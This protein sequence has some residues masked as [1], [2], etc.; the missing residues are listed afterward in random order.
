MVM[1]P[2]PHPARVAIVTAFLCL[3]TLLPVAGQAPGAGGLRPD[4][5]SGPIQDRERTAPAG[6][7]PNLESGVFQSRVETMWVQSPTFRRQ[8]Q[9]LAAERPLVVTLL[10]HPSQR[11][12]SARAST[13]FFRRN[14]RV[15]SARVAILSSTD[16]V[17][18][19]A[20]EIE[21]IIEQLDDIAPRGYSSTSS[22][23][24]AGA[25]YES[26]RAVEVGRRVAHEVEENSGRVVMRIRQGEQLRGVL[27]PASASVSAD[28][29]FIAFTSAAKLAT[30]DEDDDVDLY[31]LDLQ[32][33]R[34]T[35]ESLSSGW[36]SHYRPIVF[37]RISGNGRFIVFQAVPADEPSPHWQVVVLDRPEGTAHMVSVDS[38][39]RP[40]NGHCTQAAISAD[41]SSVV[42]ESNATNLVESGDANRNLFDIYLVRLSGGGVTRVSVASDGSRP[43]VGHSITP[44]LSGDGRYVAF[45]S[46]ADLECSRASTCRAPSDGKGVAQIYVR[47]TVSNTTSRVSRS[48]NGKAPNGPSSWPAI[49]GDGRHVVFVSEAS[50]LIR[51]DRNGEADIRQNSV[52]LH[53]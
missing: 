53:R 6:P 33:G 40:A 38:N 41:G 25:A 37:P 18:L 26:G 14:G 21:Q 1:K 28:G 9:R 22:M 8:C 48:S 20:H 16:A 29:R 49:S 11:P 46:E 35:L 51:G 5:I 42:F 34:T 2:C 32:T 31:V 24:G 44:A 52:V 4:V 30:G 47:D 12:A 3:F 7:P 45:R 19:I 27:N 15:T 43:A 10:L 39:G 36:A 17:E 13:E 23:H 50:N